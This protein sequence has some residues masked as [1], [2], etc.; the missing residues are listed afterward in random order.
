[1]NIV[2][3]L[4]E[5]LYEPKSYYDANVEYINKQ[6]ELELEFGRYVENTG[7][8]IDYKE[9]GKYMKSIFVEDS[10]DFECGVIVETFIEH[11]D[12]FDDV[13]ENF[14]SQFPI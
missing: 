7:Y 9:S 6:P 13:T 2:V 12:T 4:S 5:G 3:T 8:R 1:M 11:K 14:L 10:R